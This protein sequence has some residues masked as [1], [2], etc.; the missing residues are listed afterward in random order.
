M[1]STGFGGF[2]RRGVATVAAGRRRWYWLLPAALLALLLLVVAVSWLVEEPLRR[3]MEARL[4]ERL[5]GYTVTV[6]GLDLRPFAFGVELLDVV[7]VQDATP[8]PPV[9]SIRRLA[10]TLHGRALLRLRLVA[11]FELEEP[12]LHVDRRHVVSEAGDEVPVDERGW[13]D[14]LESIHP[15]RINEFRV[16]DGRFTYVEDGPFPPLH[17]TGINGAARNIRNVHSDDEEYPS[18]VRVDAVVFDRGR[19]V[20]DGRANFLARPHAAIRTTLALEDIALDFFRPILRR[21]NLDVR[22]GTLAAEG[23]VEYTPTGTRV[24][25]ARVTVRGPVADYV[26]RAETAE[27][28]KARAK[29]AVKTTQEVSGDPELVLRVGELEVTGATLGW[30]NRAEQPRYRVFL[31]HADIRVTNLTNQLREGETVGQVR[32]RFMGS[33]AALAVLR[34]RPRANGPDFDFRLAVEGTDMR[35]M[36]DLLRAHGKVD[37]VSGAF[38]VYSEVRVRQRE[39]RGWIKPLFGNVEIYDPEQDRDKNLLRKA[40]ERVVDVVRAILENAPRDEVATVTDLSGRLD[41]PDTSTW[42]VLANL[43]R[44]AFVKAILPG[45]DRDGPSRRRAA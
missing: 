38:S 7:V 3:Q 39:I 5:E 16:V 8:D 25:L 31:S 2:L 36:N 44:N 42:Q 45:F 29:E 33:G 43:V 34:M 9:G 13:Q 30:T 12:V 28:E 20:V 14:A 22:G 17:L 6:G 21:H 18:A 11:D 41:Q 23:E 27:R 35:T 32:G 24:D 40:W 1:A 19:L 10:A 4:N 37:V 15:F 26:H